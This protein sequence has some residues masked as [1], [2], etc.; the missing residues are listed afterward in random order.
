MQSSDLLGFQVPPLPLLQ[1]PVTDWSNAGT[2]KADYLVAERVAHTSDL[3][4]ASFV[5][6]YAYK[7]FRQPGSLGGGSDTI[8]QL[9]SI[10]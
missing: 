6:R 7:R 8:F 3:P 10:A 2:R 9:D 4:V 5:D 1:L